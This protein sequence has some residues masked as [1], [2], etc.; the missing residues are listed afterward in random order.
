MHA[1]WQ[2]G[3]RTKVVFVIC[4]G[5][6]HLASPNKKAALWQRPVVAIG[7][8]VGNC[9][10][11]GQRNAQSDTVYAA[12]IVMRAQI[13]R[14][15]GADVSESEAKIDFL[16]KCPVCG[17]AWPMNF[18]PRDLATQLKNQEPIRF[19]AMC[20]DHHWNASPE[21][22]ERIRETLGRSG[23]VSGRER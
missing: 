4:W 17:T 16:V 3:H 13:K 2:I 19:Y 21:E 8:A 23:V 5:L 1:H 10:Q 9:R 18:F 20:C 7:A 6:Y 15:G 11:G 12:G 14:E 22:A